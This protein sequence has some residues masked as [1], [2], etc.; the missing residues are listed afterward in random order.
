MTE[1]TTLPA[2]SEV[3][4]EDCWDLSQLYATADSWEADFALLEQRPAELKAFAGQLAGSPTRVRRFL[5]LQTDTFRLLRKL[6]VYAHCRCDEDTAVSEHRGLMDRVTALRTAVSESVA[7]FR[8]ELLGQDD[9]SLTRLLKARPIRP[10]R[11]ALE[12]IIREKAHTLSAAEERLL[13]LSGEIAGAPYQAFN[14]LTNADMDFGTVKDSEGNAVVVSQGMYLSVLGR[15]DRKLRRRFFRKLY[16]GY[17]AHKHTLAAT[18]AAAAKRDVFY[19]RARGFETARQAALF[20][21]NVPEAVYDNL[22]GSVRTNLEPLYRYYDLRKRALGLK[23]IRFYDL[24]VPLVGEAEVDL[25]YDH[26]VSL[27]ADAFAPLGADYVEVVRRGLESGW[28]DR[29]ENKGK[30]SGAYSSGCYD[31]P[32]YIL[33]NYRHDTLD[34][35]YTLAH[36]AGHSMHSYLSRANQ[37][38]QYADYSIFVAEVA[39]TFNE[40]LLTDHLLRLWDSPAE[41]AFLLSKQIDDLRSTLFRQVMFADFEHQ[42]HTRAEAGEPLALDHIL[43]MYREI[44]ELYFGPRFALDAELSLEC[45]RIPHFYYGYYVFQYATGISA[46]TA[47]SRDVLA[48][49]RDATARYLT[50]LSAGGSDYPLDVL[51]TAGVDMTRPDIVDATLAHFDDLV[52]QLEV[53]LKALG[54]IGKAGKKGKPKKAAKAEKKGKKAGGKGKKK[55]GK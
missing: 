42:L 21:N 7:F 41:R 9:E 12:E 30:Q 32:P 49:D 10:Y 45:L 17:E 55:K 11:F 40:A 19:A 22:V 4:A 6:Y 35:V 28:V 53:E 16:A 50:F 31:S 14:Q 44:L 43:G 46:A 25:P 3:P 18:L 48:G 54:V 38:P 24:F 20:G 36:E 27:L 15:P 39:S 33:M 23:E 29:Y 2:R 13:A 51:R 47:L 5:D 1:A 26:A 8:P 34:A 52:T 37:P